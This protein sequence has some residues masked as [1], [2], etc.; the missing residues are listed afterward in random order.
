[1]SEEM[2][3][4][5]EEF[6]DYMRPKVYEVKSEDEVLTR[7]YFRVWRQVESD[8][9]TLWFYH[10]ALLERSQRAERRKVAKQRASV[11]ADPPESIKPPE[12]PPS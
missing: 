12:E 6:Q 10:D 3:K 4:K 1:M 8:L 7:L 9:Q 11:G 2:R 5:I